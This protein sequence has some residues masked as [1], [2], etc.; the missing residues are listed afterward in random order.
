VASPTEGWRRGEGCWPMRRSSKQLLLDAF[1]AC[2][3]GLRGAGRRKRPFVRAQP[4]FQLG[5]GM[6]VDPRGDPRP[7]SRELQTLAATDKV[8]HFELSNYL[9][10]PGRRISP[11]CCRWPEMP[12][13]AFTLAP[14]T[15]KANGPPQARISWPPCKRRRTNSTPF[16]M[17]ASFGS[18][19]FG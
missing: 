19:R 3:R 11:A 8:H 9:P 12:L 2:A 10:H 1:D 14:K 18:S 7:D 5:P 16:S 4:I 13:P 15:A 17:C 6:Q